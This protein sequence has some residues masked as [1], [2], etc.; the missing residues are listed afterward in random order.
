M[1]GKHTILFDL[2]G[3]LTDSSPGI[4]RCV[5]HALRGAGIEVADPAEL[6]RFLG[7]PLTESF[8]KLYGMSHEQACRARERYRE[9]YDPVGMLENEVYPGVPGMLTALGEAG[10]TLHLATSKPHFYASRILQ[11]F[12]LAQHFGFIGGSELD[13]SREAKAEVVAHVL[14]ETGTSPDTA[15]MVGDRSHDIIGAR[16][17]GLAVV[18]V[19][20]GYGSPE[21]LADADAIAE[22]VDALRALLLEGGAA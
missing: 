13:G 12:G 3:T 9:R 8:M 10:F 22:S 5:Q 1:K 6:R 2:D 17:N 15:V 16:Q 7:P 14:R 19:G 4:T 18:G 11:H 21:E 20:Y